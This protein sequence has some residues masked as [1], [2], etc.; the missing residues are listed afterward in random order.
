MTARAL[1]LAGYGLNC[2][3]ETLHAFGHV[4]AAGQVIHINDLIE[5]PQTLDTAQILV[6]PGGF[7][8]G[9]DTGSGNAFAQKMKL[10]LWEP[11][12][13]FIARDTLTLGICNGCQII[14]TLGLV[15]ALKQHYGV[16]TVALSHNLT[17]R[18]QCRWVDLQVNT[19]SKS[20]WLKNIDRLH[21]PVAHGEGRFMMEPETLA[22]LE[23]NNQ[24]AAQYIK[25]SP[26]HPEQ[27]EGSLLDSSATP[28]NDNTWK[29]A[30]G[31][32]PHNPN[33]STADIA[34]ITDETGRILALMPH[35]ERGMFT[36]QRDDYMAAKD[37]AQ[38]TGTPLP[39]E[40]DGMALFR[41]A[42][43]YF[44]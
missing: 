31:T 25:P 27:R 34:G 24:I 23:K 11:L 21:I 3:E 35:P 16:R 10:S 8:Y 1:I 2:E 37:R 5:T 6:V 26:C 18:Y 14:T 40:T 12:L 43:G 29:L 15:P 42:V 20:P 17:A 44:S 22:T 39:E 38:R 19:A 28:Q 9:D 7:S 41:N 13:K 4:G 33:G 32:F 36:W 30:N